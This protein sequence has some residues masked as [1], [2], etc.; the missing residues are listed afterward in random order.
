VLRTFPEAWI[1]VE[2]K[3]LPPETDGREEA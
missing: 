2:L 1:N 3:S